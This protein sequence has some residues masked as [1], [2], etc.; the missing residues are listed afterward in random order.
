LF[1][2]IEQTKFS[3]SDLGR[4]LTWTLRHRLPFDSIFDHRL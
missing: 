3:A 2:S 4:I 1:H